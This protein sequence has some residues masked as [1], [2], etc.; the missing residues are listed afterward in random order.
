[1]QLDLFAAPFI[2]SVF[3]T[4]SCKPCPPKAGQRN[5]MCDCQLLH[6]PVNWM[7]AGLAPSDS[8]FTIPVQALCSMLLSANLKTPISNIESSFGRETRAARSCN[9]KQRARRGST[10]K[11]HTHGHPKIKQNSDRNFVVF[12]RCCDQTE[13][14]PAMQ[15]LSM[16]LPPQHTLYIHNIGK[17]QLKSMSYPYG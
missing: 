15:M 8:W 2:K 12:K 3:E 6:K 10:S 13:P 11:P 5:S 9:D 1:V 16:S 7:C 17:F 14:G 4:A